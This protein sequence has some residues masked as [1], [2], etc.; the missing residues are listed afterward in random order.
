MASSVLTAK[1]LG[2]ALL[3][4]ARNVN[5][6]AV[7]P[8]DDAASRLNKVALKSGP[9][10]VCHPVKGRESWPRWRHHPRRLSVPVAPLL[11]L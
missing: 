3:R 10:E 9:I 11:R 2:D 6:V 5:H 4:A 8:V 1:D 7:H